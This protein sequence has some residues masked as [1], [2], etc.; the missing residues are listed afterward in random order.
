MINQLILLLC[1][2][3]MQ[4]DCQSFTATEVWECFNLQ[5]R[6]ISTNNKCVS[7][8]FYEYNSVAVPTSVNV[9]VNC[10]LDELIHIRAIE[11]FLPSIETNSKPYY[12][13]DKVSCASVSYGSCVCCTRSQ[14]DDSM[15]QISASVELSSGCHETQGSCSFSVPRYTFTRST[16]PLSFQGRDCGAGADICHSRWVRVQYECVQIPT[17]TTST[18]TPTIYTEITQTDNVTGMFYLVYVCIRYIP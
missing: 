5:V 14:P 17:T 18:T 13:L 2:C 12:C 6:C 16:C 11:Y 3:L 10:E 15:C 8:R 9:N 7:P 1:C 4:H